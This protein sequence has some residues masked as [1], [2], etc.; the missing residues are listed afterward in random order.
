MGLTS[1]LS[2][3]HAFQSELE[4]R[5]RAA[6]VE[7]ARRVGDEHLYAFV[8]YTSHQDE[9]L[10][11]LASANTEEALARRIEEYVR[12][13]PA[14]DDVELRRG[15]RW[16]AADWGYHDFA[17]DVGAL[18]VPAARGV[19]G[20]AAIHRAFV[21]ALRTLDEEGAFGRGDTRE[22]VTLN[23]LC[24]DMGRQFFERGLRALNPATVV[25]AYFARWTPRAFVERVNARP[26]DERRHTW[27]ALYEGLALRAEPAAAVVLEAREAGLT[28]HG[29]ADE[30]A[31]LGSCVVPDLVVLLQRLARA[32]TF[33]EA[34]TPAWRRDGA[35]TREDR[36]ATNVAFVIGEIGKIDEADVACLQDIV[37]E[38]AARDRALPRAST[39][40]ENVARVL[41]GLRPRRFPDSVL[42]P[43]T[44]HLRNPEPFIAKRR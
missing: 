29:V 24:G 4:T 17:P 2:R 39:L 15:V 16:N 32:P 19:G 42:D 37:A 34:G 12:R 22:S 20:H 1:K 25:E 31:K 35:F 6:V 13:D 8:L 18:E 26:P 33:N 30:L 10:Y 36:V 3:L 11:V 28:E 5:L 9:Y 38:V 44:N 40:A 21:D 14:T 23:V 27:L 7:L 43:H 41:H